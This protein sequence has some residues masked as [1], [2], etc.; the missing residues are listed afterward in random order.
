MV[1]LPGEDTVKDVLHETNRQGGPIAV[2]AV[3]L[4]AA[5]L[6]GI[7]AIG[8]IL[9]PVMRDYIASSSKTIED[10]SNSFTDLAASMATVHRSHASMMEA[11]EATQAAVLTNGEKIAEMQRVVMQMSEIVQQAKEMMKGVPEQRLQHHAEQLEKL[12]SIDKSLQ[13]LLVAVEANST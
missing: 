12:E 6:I 4:V 8:Y 2:L 10:N 7:G 3:M 11:T 5:M 9:V 1:E 13:Q